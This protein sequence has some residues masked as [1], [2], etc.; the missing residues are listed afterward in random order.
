MKEDAE[1]SKYQV[2]NLERALAIMEHLAGNPERCTMAEIARALKYPNNSVFRI[3]STLEERGYI[4]KDASS[5]R[6]RLSRK[7]LSLGY[8]ALVE[9]GLA[10]KSHDILRSLRDETHETALLGSLLE[11]EGVVL[12]LALSPE[13]LKFMVSPGT[14]FSLHSTAPGKAIMA[15]LSETE[16]ERQLSLVKFTRFNERTLTSPSVYREELQAVRERGYS[17][18][19]EEGDKG[20]VCIGAPVFDYRKIPVAALWITGPEFRLGEAGVPAAAM[21]VMRHAKELSSRL[22]G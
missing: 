17:T 7:L 10:E 12:E 14:R 4:A 19:L 3:V 11:G 15:F 16:R 9:G 1:K 22:G 8:Q 5:G 2:P 13:P 6:L 21:M 18:D 20:V